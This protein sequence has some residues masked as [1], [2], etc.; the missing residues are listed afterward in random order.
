MK[1]ARSTTNTPSP[2]TAPTA[3]STVASSSI[4]SLN[5]R[6]D[7]IL[8]DT[9]ASLA[10]TAE[11]Q[12]RLSVDLHNLGTN[13][14]TLAEQFKQQTHQQQL[15]NDKHDRMFDPLLTT[16]KVDTSLLQTPPTSPTSSPVTASIA[17]TQLAPKF[18][19]VAFSRGDMPQPSSA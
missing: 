2:A 12:K 10:A 3:N 11:D 9:K 18:P 16:L 5:A 19:R 17:P 1:R 6:I 4:A 8:Q 15:Q 14:V 13:F 7:S